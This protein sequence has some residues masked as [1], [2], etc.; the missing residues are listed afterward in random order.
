VKITP[1]NVN[2]L[3]RDGE[4]GIYYARVKIHQKIYIRSLGE[5]ATTKEK[6]V[7]R[8]KDILQ[9]IQFGSQGHFRGCIRHI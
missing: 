5:D 4:T 3:I 2:N 6:A 7:L 9:Q 1:T 8:L